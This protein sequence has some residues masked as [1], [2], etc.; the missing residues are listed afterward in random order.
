[1]PTPTTNPNLAPATFQAMRFRLAAAQKEN[2][3]QLGFAVKKLH[4]QGYD[5]HLKMYHKSHRTAF[6]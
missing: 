6:N 2:T 1:M 3:H 5:F 4:D